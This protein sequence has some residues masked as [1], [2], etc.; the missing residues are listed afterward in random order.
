[1]DDTQPGQLKGAYI[2]QP[3][4][5]VTAE[6]VQ[7]TTTVT[8]P[9]ISA[10]VA[11][12][13]YE[14]TRGQQWPQWMLRL[15]S[16]AEQAAYA[17]AQQTFVAQRNAYHKWV[18][19]CLEEVQTYSGKRHPRYGRIDVRELPAR[20]QENCRKFAVYGEIWG[21]NELL[22]IVPPPSALTGQG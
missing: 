11:G 9:A 2:V 8:G 18:M 15:L 5:P 19:T 16:T 13:R 12:R 7:I 21:K 10:T 22:V 4:R 20:A 14:G 3:L 1:M 17:A 6:N